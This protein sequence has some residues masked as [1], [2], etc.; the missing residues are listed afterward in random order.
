M[1]ST[2][3]K[4]NATIGERDSFCRL[5][6][7]AFSSVDKG[8][9]SI[10]F[11][12]ICVSSLC[13]FILLLVSI[14][15]PLVLFGRGQRASTPAKHARRDFYMSMANCFAAGVFLSAC[16]LGLI[17]HAQQ[18]EADYIH[19]R[20][21]EDN[22]GASFFLFDCFAH[23]LLLRYGAR[24]A[25]PRSYGDDVNRRWFYADYGTRTDGGILRK[26]TVDS[27]D[28]GHRS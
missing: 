2:I 18:H 20:M 3:P 5:L 1:T 28:S 9:Y 24:H 15:L 19:R 4:G 26:S 6:I 22:E 17:P 11:A 16:I 12:V 13:T 14:L 23:S 8:D 21:V 10:S 27:I 7:L 25:P